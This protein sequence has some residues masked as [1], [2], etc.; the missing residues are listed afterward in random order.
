MTLDQFESVIRWLG[1][2]LAYTA[3]GIVLVGVWR[4]T[5][6]AA[7]RTMGFYSR[8]LRSPWFYLVTSAVYF[9]ISYLCWTPLPWQVSPTARLWVLIIGS[10]LYFPGMILIV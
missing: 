8:W 4:G 7:G 9:G 5:R 2:V 10:L 1:G 6:R 3:L